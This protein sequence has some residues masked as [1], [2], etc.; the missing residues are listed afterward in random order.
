M[1]KSKTVRKNFDLPSS[2]SNVFQDLGFDRKTAE[3]LLIRGELAIEIEKEI[4]RRG[5]TQK[6]AASELGVSQP[7]ISEL[8]AGQL[9]KFTID[10]LVQFLNQLGVSVQLPPGADP[11]P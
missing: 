6:Q 5:W 2:G 3:R 11:K 7:R 9:D 10:T 1:T 4:T 8:L